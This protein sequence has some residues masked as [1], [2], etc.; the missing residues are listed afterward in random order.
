M[1]KVSP[2]PP[3]ECQLSAAA[4]RLPVSRT[5]SRTRGFP[6]PHEHCPPSATGNDD[7]R[8]T[9]RQAADCNTDLAGHVHNGSAMMWVRCLSASKS[10][11]RR[12]DPPLRTQRA[13]PLPCAAFGQI[14]LRIHQRALV[15]LTLKQ[16]QSLLGLRHC[17]LNLRKFR[18]RGLSPHIRV[19]NLAPTRT[20]ASEN[21]VGRDEFV[22]D[23]DPIHV[24]KWALGA[25]IF[26]S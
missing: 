1:S 3:P 21:C 25:E 13:P 20:R 9:N 18:F 22:H 8:A 4:S 14:F 10:P 26:Q 23:H 15:K 6:C 7:D 19:I 24:N 17:K 16:R 5:S 11:L 2:P 12:Q